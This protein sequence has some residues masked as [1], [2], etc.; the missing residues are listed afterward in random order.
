MGSVYRLTIPG[1][2]KVYIGSTTMPLTRRL[3]SHRC[4]FKRFQRGVG[5]NCGSFH[6]F[7]LVDDPRMVK[8]E[9]IEIV[10]D[11]AQLRRRETHHQRISKQPLVNIQIAEYKD[12]RPSR[13]PIYCECGTFLSESIKRKKHRRGGLHERR[14]NLKL[15]AELP[16]SA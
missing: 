7:E 2:N 16:L 5:A 10:A 9:L 14:W 8:I 3:T 12:S 15:L 13:R 1:N 6:L 11:R 4:H